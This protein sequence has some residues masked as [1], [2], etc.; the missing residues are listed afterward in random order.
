MARARAKTL[1]RAAARCEGV[2]S[3][4]EGGCAGGE[5]EGVLRDG[6]EIGLWLWNRKMRFPRNWGYSSIC[7]DASEK[8]MRVVRAMLEID[9]SCLPATEMGRF[10][11]VCS[12]C[13]ECGELTGVL[14]PSNSSFRSQHYHSC[15]A[16]FRLNS[17]SKSGCH[18]R[19][20][21]VSSTS[22]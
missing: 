16:A 21:K 3:V 10:A 14:P 4:E 12:V 20:I 2:G 22:W 17:V 9:D 8:G 15:R 5:G 18:I 11:A 19:W 1:R 7:C 6:I 13:F